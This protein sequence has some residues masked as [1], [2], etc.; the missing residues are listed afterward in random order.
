MNSAW[1]PIADH[2]RSEI[3][4]YGGL[5]H[6]FEQQQR[7]L[8]SRNADGVYGAAAGARFYGAVCGVNV[9]IA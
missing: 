2:L 3:A 1:S 9:D 6:L 8:F 7:Q 4:E 5:L